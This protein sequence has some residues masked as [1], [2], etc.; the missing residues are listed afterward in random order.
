MS[1]AGDSIPRKSRFRIRGAQAPAF[2]ALHHATDPEK[3][4]ASIIFRRFFA[5]VGRPPAVRRPSRPALHAMSL[6][7]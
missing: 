7:Q 4:W 2:A 1:S 6:V 5:Q 3:Y